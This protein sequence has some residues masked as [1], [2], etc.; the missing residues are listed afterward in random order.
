MCP[1]FS[2]MGGLFKTRH[3]VSR[4]PSGKNHFN[5]VLQFNLKCVVIK[6]LNS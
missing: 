6:Y 3:T 5:N 2:C 4:G 1:V